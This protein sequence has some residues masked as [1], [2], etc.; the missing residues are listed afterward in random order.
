MAVQPGNINDA[1][2][3]ILLATRVA[4]G[5]MPPLAEAWVSLLHLL[6][7][8]KYLDKEEVISALLPHKKGH[9]GASLMPLPEQHGMLRPQRSFAP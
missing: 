6:Y 4:A 1:H 9:R 7:E 3:D 5:G 2:P 8:N